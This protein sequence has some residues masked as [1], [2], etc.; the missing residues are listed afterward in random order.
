M[1]LSTNNWRDIQRYYESCFT[2]FPETGDQIFLIRSVSPNLI[3]GR[4]EDG[5]PLNC[6]LHQEEDQEPY[7]LDYILPKKSY[8]E[9]NGRACLLS[10][11]PARQYKRGL[12]ADNTQIVALMGDGSFEKLTIDFPVLGAYIQKQN[13]RSFGEGIS[14]SSV[15]LSPRI[16]LTKSGHLFVDAV[17]IGHYDYI[18]KTITTKHKAFKRELEE[19]MQRTNEEIKIVFK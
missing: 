6:F 11:I 15:A 10:R 7:L 9:Y 2:K 14:H 1:Y 13:F 18:S 12:S 3:E 4:A 17:R 8:F 19:I 16:A 5:T